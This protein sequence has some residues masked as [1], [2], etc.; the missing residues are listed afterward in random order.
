MNQEND[1]AQVALEEALQNKNPRFF[2]ASGG[3]AHG[4]T[5][6]QDTERFAEALMVLQEC[7]LLVGEKLEMNA[8]SYA[9]MYDG[10]ETVGFRFDQSSDPSSPE[11]V[12]A[13]QNSRVSMREF[14]Q[15][16]NNFMLSKEG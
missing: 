3:S 7:S 15:S 1:P 14:T 12:G 13:I 9:Y 11:V 6:Y 16:M 8:V 4:R 2:R 5:G 10:E